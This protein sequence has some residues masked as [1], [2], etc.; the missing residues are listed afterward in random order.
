MLPESVETAIINIVNETQGLKATEL[1][2][3]LVERLIAK[4]SMQ[5]FDLPQL[6]EDLVKKHLI[7]EVEYI[8][9]Q[10]SYRTKSFLLPAGTKVMLTNS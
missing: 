5:P 3:K 2:V 8:V 10:V 4:D 1:A 6:L 9:P 7:V